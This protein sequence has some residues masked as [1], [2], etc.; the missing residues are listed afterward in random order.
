MASN[1]SSEISLRSAWRQ[2]QGNIENFVGGLAAEKISAAY[3]WSQRGSG[4]S[5]TL[6]AHIASL[7]QKDEKMKDWYILYMVPTEVECQ[8][9][10][11]HVL[12]DAFD[13]EVGTEAPCFHPTQG[14]AS[15][16]IT[17]FEAFLLQPNAVLHVR[18]SLL[19]VMDLEVTPSTCSEIAMGMV[20]DWA[21]QK[22]H[23]K[24]FGNGLVVLAPQ[25][26]PT[27]IRALDLACEGP[28]TKIRVPDVQLKLKAAT[29]DDDPVKEINRMMRNSADPKSER[30][31]MVGTSTPFE[32]RLGDGIPHYF[33]ESD[34]AD[35]L[36]AAL[37]DN[38]PI[39]VD[40]SVPFSTHDPRLGAIFSFGRV[41]VKSFMPD[42]GQVVTHE[43]DMTEAEI[44]REQ[45]WGLKSGFLPDDVMFFPLYNDNVK[46]FPGIDS[47]GKAYGETMFWTILEVI[48]RW[49][50]MPFT[51]M[52]IREMQ[53]LHMIKDVC[54]K[55]QLN[56][57]IA[58]EGPLAGIYKL[59]RRGQILLELLRSDPRLEFHRAHFIAGIREH[60][61]SWS[62]NMKRVAIRL[63]ALMSAQSSHCG[64]DASAP[65]PTKAELKK[66][67]IGVGS[68]ERLLAGLWAE[69][70]IWQKH[71]AAGNAT[72]AE[73]IL[74]MDWLVINPLSMT[75][76]TQEV[77]DLET[78]FSI[79][80]TVDEVQDTELTNSELDLLHDELMWSWI[81][82]LMVFVNPEKDPQAV[83]RD[84]ASALGLSMSSQELL[85][86]AEVASTRDFRH[87]FIAIYCGLRKDADGSYKANGVTVVPIKSL[88]CIRKR[89]VPWSDSVT[90]S[91]SHA[92]ADLSEE[93]IREILGRAPQ[94]RAPASQSAALDVAL[95]AAAA[96]AAADDDDVAPA[97]SQLA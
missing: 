30:K 91:L 83:P 75:Q 47:L 13:P 92:R 60:E 34:T 6:L 72:A 57:S 7:F 78:K 10:R 77:E 65:A 76:I 33:I 58:Q 26:S 85:N 27:T 25:N 93:Q 12:S 24:V 16:S 23:G 79:N 39:I 56:G 97:T 28:T 1:P 17:S 43:R 86:V 9:L 70:G 73:G 89:T 51:H 49:P 37:T 94:R 42:I 61:D 90:G 15:V 14:P 67:C 4:K 22:Q 3:I 88:Q 41:E 36:L 2:K 95:A 53:D 71:K 55:L 96:A 35:Q 31:V 20:F 74:R 18:T 19:V 38:L 68:D 45:S 82:Q 80:P 63:A 64:K 32:Y 21:S 11:K 52:P 5:T 29:L 81:D 66:F 50:G 84:A 8:L 44:Q 46:R 40:P 59:S 87:G 48:D 69:L 62:N 54:R